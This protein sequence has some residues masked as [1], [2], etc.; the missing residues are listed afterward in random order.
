MITTNID[1]LNGLVNGAIGT[2]RN[3]DRNTETS[4]IKR[5][6]LYF[7]D[8]KIGPLLRVK[9]QAHLLANPDLDHS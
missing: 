4:A 6:L 1:L 8:S 9:A 2:L 7:N 5:L 3:I